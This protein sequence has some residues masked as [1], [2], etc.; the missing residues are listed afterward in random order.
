MAVDAFISYSHV[1][2]VTADATCAK[3]EAAGVRCWIA[4]RD[5]PPG[6]EWA[7]A[8]VGAI[9]CCRVFVLIFS[10]QANISGQIHR[11]VER[12]ASKGIPIVPLRIEEVNPTSSLE[13]F[14]G[15]IHWLD[16]LTPPLE[17]HLQRL[18]EVV[19]SCLDLNQNSISPI[20][21][22]LRSEKPVRSTPRRWRQWAVFGAL[23]LV[24]VA[25]SG[26]ALF[27]L[28]H[29]Q[30]ANVKQ[31]DEVAISPIEQLASPA[32]GNQQGFPAAPVPHQN[33]PTQVPLPNAATPV[34]PPNTAPALEITA[35][36]PNN[37]AGLES[38]TPP[39]K[40]VVFDESRVRQL[41]KTLNIQLPHRLSVTEPGPSVPARLTEFIG[42]WV[43]IASRAPRD[44]ILIIEDVD[45]TGRVTGIYAVGPP[46][47]GFGFLPKNGPSY[48]SFRAP[49]TGDGFSFL[50][51]PVKFS[52]NRSPG[53]LILGQGHERLD[54]RSNDW[55]MR[56]QRIE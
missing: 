10:A 44:S 24:T 33:A 46:K 6:S 27:Y 16:A 12:A 8:I 40:R 31:A 41:A 1:D 47:F 11:E 2:K 15:N 4:P 51:G 48:T 19:K 55:E 42:A 7:A 3:L 5:V 34:P 35:S 39:D 32:P 38:K 28:K 14:L 36:L 53:N 49:V 18:L 25:C 45:K 13:Y 30:V 50:W 26:A 9:D 17:R 37:E 22:P 20:A 43:R 54:S 52:F 56:F 23:Y 21:A 29:G